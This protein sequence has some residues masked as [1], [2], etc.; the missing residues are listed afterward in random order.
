MVK[1]RLSMLDQSS[2]ICGHTAVQAVHE[3]IKLAQKWGGQ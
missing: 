3:S 2:I 1:F